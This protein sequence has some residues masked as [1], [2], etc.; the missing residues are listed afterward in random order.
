MISVAR[1]LGGGHHG[2][3]RGL[4]SPQVYPHVGPLQSQKLEA[5][6]GRAKLVAG[7]HLKTCPLIGFLDYL[8]DVEIEC[9]SSRCC[10]YLG[11]LALPYPRLTNPP[12]PYPGIMGD[13][14]IAV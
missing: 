12:P 9:R 4:N 1:G 3:G 7:P 6:T 13:E 5:T 10:H 14:G 8:K 2:D 11:T